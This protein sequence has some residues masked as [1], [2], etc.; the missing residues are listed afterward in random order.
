[1][2]APDFDELP[3]EPSLTEAILTPVD[4]WT[5]DVAMKLL[6]ETNGPKVEIFRGRAIMS[7]H[8]GVDHQ[9]IGRQLAYPLHRAA[10]RAGFWAYPEINVI[11][12]DDLYIPDVSVFRKSGAGQ[13]AMDIADALM[14]VEIVSASNRRRDVIDRPRAYAAAKVP[15]FMRIEFRKR[16]P[17][18]VLHELIDGEYQPVLACAAGTTFAMTEPFPFS[19]DPAALLDD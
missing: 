15:W 6:P 10:R 12:G 8:A 3:E 16:V 17:S 18:I 9:T 14:L 19:I 4:E 1:M 13:L 7:P 11:D 2:A 5:A